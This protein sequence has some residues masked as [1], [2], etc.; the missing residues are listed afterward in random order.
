MI[1]LDTI[2]V[3]AGAAGLIAAR[4][5]GRAG[6]N[7]T[8]FDARNRTGGRVHTSPEPG[9]SAPLELGAEFIH[10]RLPH[11]FDLLK[12]YNLSYKRVKGEIWRVRREGIEQEDDFL[13]DQQHQL[14]DKLKALK[15]D[16]TVDQF[17]REYFSGPEYEELARMVRGFVEGYDAADAGRASAIAFR[18]EWLEEDPGAQ[19]R[20]NGGY[21]ALIDKLTQDCRENG[22]RFL[23]SS[24]VTE[25]HWKRDFAEIVTANGKK[26]TASRVLITLPL[27]V[28]ASDAGISFV[29]PVPVKMAAAAAMGFGSVTK[30]F[31]QFEEPFWK[32]KTMGDLV[33]KNLEDLGFLFS[34]EPVP[35]WWTQAPETIPLL[36]GWLSGPNA[37]KPGMESSE[38]L[39][40]QALASLSSIFKSPVPE[41][42]ASKVVN[43]SAEPFTRGAYS[44]ATVDA[45]RHIDALIQPLENTVFF[46]GEELCNGKETG[47]VEAAFASGLLAARDILASFAHITHA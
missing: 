15:E 36:T 17:L 8:V 38:M 12:E 31:F 32:S 9:F 7:V 45:K 37:L 27:G 43:W 25:I 34:N 18:N 16:M 26:Y 46:A 3:G 19:Y 30:I 1:N 35:T 20:I 33:G 24:A 44:Y 11:T 23:L 5:L 2:I 40:K 47:T 29:P 41:P 14:E 22:C 4:Q 10:G 6:R 39:V 13:D 42:V 28:L 21:G